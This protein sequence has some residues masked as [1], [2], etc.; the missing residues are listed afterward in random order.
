ME[1]IL[2]EIGQCR[3]GLLQH[4]SRVKCKL[5]LRPQIQD[6]V[7]ELGEGYF[8]GEEAEN[9]FDRMAL[10]TEM[11]ESKH[12]F[13]E[14]RWNVEHL[15]AWLKTYGEMVLAE[16]CAFWL[17]GG[18]LPRGTEFLSLSYSNTLAKGRNLWWM[19]GQLVSQIR[20]NKAQSQTGKWASWESDVG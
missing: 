8:F 12:F 14:G 10:F 3:E 20:Y 5:V 2:D 11:A 6:R 9:G 7:A 4:L 13:A 17:G 15:Q 1:L 19:N 16:A 18:G